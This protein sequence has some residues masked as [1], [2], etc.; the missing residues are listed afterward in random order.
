MPAKKTTFEDARGIA[1]SF[2][3]VEETTYWRS[4]A[5]KLRGNLVAVVPTHKSAEKDSLAVSVDLDRRAELLENAPDIYYIKEHYANYPV[6]LVRL[7]KI[8]QG[9]LRDLLSGACKFASAK[10]PAAKRR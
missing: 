9:S 5:F 7:A 10:K 3:G 1:L 8:D 2:P 4:P 6:V